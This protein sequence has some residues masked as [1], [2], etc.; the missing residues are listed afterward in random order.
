LQF[1]ACLNLTEIPG[2]SKKKKQTN[3]NKT[4]KNKQNKTENNTTNKQHQKGKQI[5][6]KKEQPKQSTKTTT[7][8]ITG[9]HCYQIRVISHYWM[10][11]GSPRHL[12]S[13]RLE[14][15]PVPALHVNLI[16]SKSMK[17]KFNYVKKFHALSKL[18]NWKFISRKTAIVFKF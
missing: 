9:K 18:N 12:R 17:N 7:T 8:T 15:H 5:I 6:I 16:S 14:G 10:G 11:V 2:E 4:N 3:K 1:P 13:R